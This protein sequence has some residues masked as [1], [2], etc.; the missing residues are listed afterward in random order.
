MGNRRKAR[1]MALQILYQ[2]D[3]QERLSD[4]Q[5]LALFWENFAQEDA[6]LDEGARGFADSLVQGVREHLTEIDALITRA[7]RNWRIERMA[8]VDRNLI[9]LALHELKFC[10][11]VPS[12]VAINE[13]IE[14]AK[15]YGTAESPA[16]VNG[17][18]DRC[19]AEL[20]PR[21]E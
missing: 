5:G 14:I 3:V 19:L 18:L 17:I 10:A 7:S 11:D 1:E 2:L 12:K 4:E 20:G 6:E 21:G 15:R 13:A 16:F 8:R 9:R